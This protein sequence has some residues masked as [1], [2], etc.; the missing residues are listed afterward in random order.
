MRQSTDE[1]TVRPV[2]RAL[3]YRST[4]SEKTSFPSGDST[5]GSENIASR[6]RR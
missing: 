3:R 1:R 5:I 6:A 2:R 4:A